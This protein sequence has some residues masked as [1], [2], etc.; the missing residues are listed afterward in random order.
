[1]VFPADQF[2][3]GICNAIL[4]EL[5]GYSIDRLLSES[6]TVFLNCY[7]PAG[8]DHSQ[9]FFSHH[10]PLRFTKRAAI[11]RKIADDLIKPGFRVPSR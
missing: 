2:S 10:D 7:K 5:F 9:F 4:T 11:C 1:M 8:R 3:S 6:R